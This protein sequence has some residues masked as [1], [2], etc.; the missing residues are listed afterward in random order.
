M[1]IKKLRFILLGS[2]VLYVAF[3]PVWFLFFG[4]SAVAVSESGSLLDQVSYYAVAAYPFVMLGAVILSWMHYRRGEAKK[5]LMINGLPMLW[6]IP[7]LAL[8][9]IANI[10]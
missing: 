5:M 9:F 3:L 2:H 8:F 7:I 1:K 4:V 6:I 10:G